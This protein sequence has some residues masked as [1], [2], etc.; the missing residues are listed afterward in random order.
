MEDRH[1]PPNNWNS[2]KQ[3]EPQAFQYFFRQHSFR[4]YYY[5]L[6]LFRDPLPAAELTEQVFIILF[7]NRQYLRDEEHLLQCTYLYARIG[8][9]LRLQGKRYITGI[10]ERLAYHVQAEAGIMEEPGIAE[11]ETLV[12]LESAVQK[13]PPVKREIAELYF[14]LGLSI[15]A[16][17][18][19]LEID[20]QYI[21]ESISV[22]L[23]KL[24]QELSGSDPGSKDFFMV[25]ASVM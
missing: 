2:F 21:K 14:F 7:N 6:R 12:A 22:S 24:A 1:E 9:Q 3:G 5:L 15:K 19:R 20:E 8:Y 17:A 10:E 13:L 4:I 18:R 25:R 23:K 16:I 11:N